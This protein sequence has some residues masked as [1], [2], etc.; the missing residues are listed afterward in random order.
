MTNEQK[1]F[2]EK[3]AAAVKKN[4]GNYGIEVASPIIAQAIIESN[5]G[6]SGLSANYH[7]YFGLK[8]G[9]AWKGASVNMATK[10]EY[11][12]GVLTSINDNFRVFGSLEEG[13]KGYFDFIN[14]TRYANLKG[15]ADPQKYVENIKSDGY[16]TSSSYVNT[17]MNCVRTYDLTAYDAQEAVE[18]LKDEETVAREVI[19]GIWGNGEA[20]KAKLTA[21]GYNYSNIQNKVNVLLGK[22]TKPNLKSNEVISQ[23]IIAGKWGNNPSR[24]EK[25]IAAGYDYDAIQKIVNQKLS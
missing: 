12:P 2:I 6:K 7:N 20:R 24:K 3:I 15:V 14:T 5:W 9:S 25:L 23:E 11:K 10:E 19:N 18:P 21:A 1:N 8:C 16:A 13:V 17:I 4:M 22:S